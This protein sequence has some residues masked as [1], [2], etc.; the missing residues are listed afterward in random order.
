MS[1]L[2]QTEDPP[3]DRNRPLEPVPA[4]SPKILMVA[5]YCSPFKGSDWR[6]G[7]GRALQAAQS[8]RVLVIT[9]EE[10]R[11]DIER[12]LGENGPIPNLRFVFLGEDKGLSFG[13]LRLSYLYVNPFSY[14][15]WQRK[16]YRLAKE[17]HSTQGF[18]LT[19]QVNL[20]GFREPGELW[21]LDIPFVWGPIGGTQ[22]LPWP[23]LASGGW[24]DML[25]EGGRSVLNLLQMHFSRKVHSAL[26][27]AAVVMVANSHGLE[28]FKRYRPDC[29]QLL[30]TG[31]DSVASAPR[32]SDPGQPLHILWS[33]EIHFR[34]ALHL[35]LYALAEIR[36][37][38]RFEVRILGRGAGLAKAQK[39]AKELGVED[40]CRFL[41]WL[42]L[43]QAMDQSRWADVFVFTSLRDTSGNVMLEAMSQGV[44]VIT[45]DHQ[46]AG[47][48][49]TEQSGIKIP[50]ISPSD[51]T[52]RFAQALISL[53][54][55]RKR[56]ERLSE[57]AAARA[58]EF[59]WERNAKRMAVI[60][61]SVLEE[62]LRTG[63]TTTVNLNRSYGT[64]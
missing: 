12:Y 21:K 38:T 16:A 15:K 39:L 53:G 2:L 19:H 55:N 52:R 56:L 34:K 37:A 25:L 60:Y 30:E 1:T 46:G 20:I 5:F 51:A 27:R 10:S 62:P 8:F 17:L 7:W 3:L 61:N 14:R 58:K 64:V 35:L 4:R 28:T 22:F 50:V 45:F 6:V 13:K 24:K 18:D 59:L 63:A 23:F 41:G 49:V 40:R 29:I 31:L 57:G 11:A 9:S 43:D 32:V 44:P 47:D 26:K 54:Q 48:I 42:P 36:G 33:G